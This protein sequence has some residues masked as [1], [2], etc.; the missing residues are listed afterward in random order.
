MGAIYTLCPVTGQEVATGIEADALTLT[1]VPA[2]RSRI[3]CPHCGG[4]H[5]WTQAD[6]WIRNPDG[7]VTQWPKP[8]K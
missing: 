1:R 5:E 8:E 7:S 3:R 4:E 6:A 2:F